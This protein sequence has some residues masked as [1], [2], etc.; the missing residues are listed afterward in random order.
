MPSKKHTPEQA[1]LFDAGDEEASPESGTRRALMVPFGKFK[2][3]PADLLLAHSEYALWLLAAKSSLLRRSHPQMYSWLVSHFGL[4][5]TTPEHNRLQNRFLD[6][7]FRLQVFLHLNPNAAE[8]PPRVVDP[9]AI[10]QGWKRILPSRVSWASSCAYESVG[11]MKNMTLDEWNSKLQAAALEQIRRDI[12][13]IVVDCSSSRAATA[14]EQARFAVAGRAPRVWAPVFTAGAPKFEVDGS[15][16]DF[17]VDSDFVVRVDEP[18]PGY[19][20]MEHPSSS[21]LTYEFKRRYRVEVKPFVGDDYPVILR[22]MVAKN[23]NLLLVEAFEADGATWE[24]VEQVFASRSIRVA[25]LEDVLLTPISESVRCLSLPPL[26]T[27]ALNS[28]AAEELGGHFEGVRKART[29]FDE[30]RKTHWDHKTGPG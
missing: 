21:L 11:A 5:D 25:L 28:L 1:G 17:S 9:A 3:Q 7:D 20:S 10:V 8:Q 13:K 14:D 29:N 26:D 15:D 18:Q 2:D 19:S 12:G 16:V 23:C 22:S 4:P 27:G 6:D 24:Q 30:L